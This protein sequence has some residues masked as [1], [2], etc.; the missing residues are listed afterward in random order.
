MVTALGNRRVSIKTMVVPSGRNLRFI[1]GGG[2][3]R[4]TSGGEFFST[5]LISSI[6]TDDLVAEFGK[7]FAMKFLL[8]K[9]FNSEIPYFEYRFLSLAYYVSIFACH[10]FLFV[11]TIVLCDSIIIK[12]SLFLINF[13]RI[14]QVK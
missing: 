9:L 14:F 12:C 13:G 4:L 11:G 6:L 8:E 1:R 10:M 2:P 7:Y 5:T 3:G